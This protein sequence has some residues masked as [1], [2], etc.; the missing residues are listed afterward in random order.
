[1]AEKEKEYK[2]KFGIR[3]NSMIASK[4]F[5]KITDYLCN[6]MAVKTSICSF[7]PSISGV[8]DANGALKGDSELKCSVNIVPN[9]TLRDELGK[10]KIV[11]NKIMESG[12]AAI[13]TVTNRTKGGTTDG[14][15]GRGDFLEL[16]G[17]KIKCLNADGSGIGRLLLESVLGVQ[18][19]ITLLIYNDPSLVAFNVP[20][21]LAEGSYTLKIETYYTS[22]N[23][24]LKTP[25][26]IICPIPIVI[27]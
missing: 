8:F 25:R 21:D 14:R 11:V 7:L 22:G 4:L 17:L 6:G 15:A 20:E 3:E 24:L 13:R 1:M 12:G 23:N 5:E 19:D 16:K 10:V 26:E 2:W 18:T 9:E 27:E